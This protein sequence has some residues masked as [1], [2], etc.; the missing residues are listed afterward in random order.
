ME[1]PDDARPPL[2]VYCAEP[3]LGRRGNA[4]ATILVAPDI[5]GISG[6]QVQQVCDALAERSGCRV[7]LVDV[8]RGDH[9]TAEI[10]ATRFVPWVRQ[11]DA[12]G[13]VADFVRAKAALGGGAIRWGVAGF[14]WGSWAALLVAAAS[15]GGGGGFGSPL[16]AVAVAHP[17]H[18]KL[19]EVHGM[20]CDRLVAACSPGAAYLLLP[21]GNDDPR[22][23]AGGRDELGLLAATGSAAPTSLGAAPT[24]SSFIKPAS[25]R[26]DV[27]EFTAMSHGFVLRGD[28][29]GSAEVAAAVDR[30]VGLLAAAFKASLY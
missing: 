18:R 9:C 14:C 29:A 19:C 25:L 20:D 23:R 26:V 11:F 21:C 28:V 15:S 22:S 8:F 7:L 17:S 16:C 24:S 6:G 30:A 13:V 3:P 5:Y 12:T 2:E 4:P 1:F 10:R 27:R